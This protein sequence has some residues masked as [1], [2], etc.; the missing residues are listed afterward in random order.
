MQDKKY[1]HLTEESGGVRPHPPRTNENVKRIFFDSE[2]T[3]IYQTTELISFGAIADCGTSFY[4]E[5]T[6]VDLANVGDWI[7]KNVVPHLS[8]VEAAKKAPHALS[9]GT[10]NDVSGYGDLAFIGDTF[11][12]WASTWKA[13]DKIELWA[14]VKD[15]D[16]ILFNNMMLKHKQ[17]HAKKNE[18]PKN[19]HYIIHEFAT[20]LWAKGI[21]PDISRETFAEMLQDDDSILNKH[22]ALYDAQVLK[23]CFDKAYIKPVYGIRM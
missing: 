4:M 14:D 8:Y 22:N 6:D 13:F 1:F 7:K 19:L 12:K 23:K 11:A 18:P 16:V 21:D 2:F 9:W 17:S 5:N 20:F 3:G 10:K 15:Y